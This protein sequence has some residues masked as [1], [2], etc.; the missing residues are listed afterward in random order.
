MGAGV[1]ASA[2]LANVLITSVAIIIGEKNF[3][4]WLTLWTRDILVG[5]DKITDE[6]WNH[7]PDLEW[8]LEKLAENDKAIDLSPLLLEE[9]ELVKGCMH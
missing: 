2:L 4:R 5:P 6:G 3:A 7:H 8:I 9:K 1:L